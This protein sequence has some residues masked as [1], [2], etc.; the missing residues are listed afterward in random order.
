MELIVLCLTALTLGLR[1]GLD[2][3]H[4]AAM[5]DMA[6]A[7]VKDAPSET[8]RWTR[9]RQTIKLPALYVLGHAVMILVLGVA[10]LLFGAVVPEWVDTV[11]ERILGITLLLLSGYLIYSLTTVFSNG[12][13]LKLRSRWMVV[14]ASISK[15]WHWLKSKVV[16]NHHHHHDKPADGSWDAKGSFWIGMIHGFGAETGTQVLLFA[17]VLGTG[18]GSV[19]ILLLLSFIVGMAISTLTIALAVSAGLTSS[20]Y[21]KPAL[22]VLGI[23]A[24]IFSLVVGLYFTFGW[25]E[26]LPTF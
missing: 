24:A 19:G 15:A 6:G 25:S 13:E 26:H 12:G 1:H 7:S 20:V 3:D 16:P 23:L 4:I 10:A 11:M 5:L 8:S 21:F 17:S 18:S 22:L 2:F 14:F 9:I